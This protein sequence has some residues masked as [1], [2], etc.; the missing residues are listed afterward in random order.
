MTVFT[1]VSFSTAWRLTTSRLAEYASQ[2]DFLP[3]CCT[4]TTS[5]C[6]TCS[7]ARSRV[8]TPFHV[9][10]MSSCTRSRVAE[11]AGMRP[12]GSPSTNVPPP[13]ATTALPAIMS[14][15]LTAAPNSCANFLWPPASASCAGVFP[16]SS[17]ICDS[18]PAFS[19][20][21]TT[22]SWPPA[23]ASCRGARPPPFKLTT[24]SLPLALRMAPTLSKCPAEDALCSGVR[25]A[26]FV[27]DTMPSKGSS[28]SRQ[29]TKFPA[30]AR[31]TAV[32]PFMSN[33]VASAPERSRALT[34]SDL[35]FA[36]AT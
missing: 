34:A 28:A 24:F 11:L 10:S 1:S 15:S 30:A 14:S 35:S 19:R 21:A 3:F 26:S 7:N 22:A 27:S 5:K 4:C 36:T 31:C 17:A 6:A 12:S 18:A 33:S 13:P 32:S 25:P 20:A 16:A 8:V 29:A 23:A 2:R 9:M